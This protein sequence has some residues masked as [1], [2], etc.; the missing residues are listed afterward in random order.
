MCISLDHWILDGMN[1]NIVLSRDKAAKFTKIEKCYNMNQ[2]HFNFMKQNIQNMVIFQLLHQPHCQSQAPALASN[3]WQWARLLKASDCV[4][5]ASPAAAKNRK[6][7][8]AVVGCQPQ[9]ARK[10][11][12]TQELRRDWILQS[13]FECFALNH[14][15]FWPWNGKLSISLAKHIRTRMNHHRYLFNAVHLWIVLY[16][17]I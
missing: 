2:I 3:P 13:D 1:I 8:T 5:F 11:G 6:R 17:Y 16:D 4:G 15:F 7:S 12:V 14:L 9:R 10:W